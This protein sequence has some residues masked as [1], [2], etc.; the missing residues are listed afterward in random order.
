MVARRCSS[1]V[2]G[3]A[4]IRLSSRACAAHHRKSP[5]CHP[6]D[7]MASRCTLLSSHKKPGGRQYSGAQARQADFMGDDV[8]DASRDAQD[9]ARDTFP[10]RLRG[11]GQARPGRPAF[12]EKHL[13]I[14]QTWSWQQVNDKV[15]PIDCGLASLSFKRG[16]NLAIVGDNRPSLYWAMLAAQSLGGVPVPLYQDAPAADMAYV[17]NDADIGFAV[18]E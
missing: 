12:R 7:N 13:G 2:G 17:L 6:K 8:V 5:N 9:Q 11:H 3:E 4:G 1:R 15:L 10:R 18:A 16:M 14:W